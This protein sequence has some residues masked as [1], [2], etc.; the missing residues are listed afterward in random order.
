MSSRLQDLFLPIRTQFAA[1]YFMI[2]QRG[3]TSADAGMLRQELMEEMLG[4]PYVSSVMFGDEAGRQYLVMRYGERVRTSPLLGDV[5]PERVPDPAMGPMIFTREVRPVAWGDRSEWTFWKLEGEARLVESWSKPLPGYDPRERPWHQLAMQRLRAREGAGVRSLADP[6]PGPDWTEVYTFFTTKTPGISATLAARTP[7]G[8]VQIIAYDL[9][10]D[11]IARFTREAVVSRHGIVCVLTDDDRILGQSGKA[12][13]TILPSVEEGGPPSLQ[14]AVAR[15]RSRG[16]GAT[17]SFEFEVEGRSWWAGFAPYEIQAGRT[18]WIGVLAP[19]SDLLPEVLSFRVTLLV[20]GGSVLVLAL[21]LAFWLARRFAEPLEALAQQSEAT[22]RLDWEGLAPVTGPVAEIDTLARA[23]AQMRHALREHVD[24]RAEAEDALAR[25]EVRY[26]TLIDSAV[27]GVLVVKDQRVVFANAAA[28]AILNPKTAT[29]TPSTGDRTALLD[30]KARASV[31]QALA[32]AS[33]PASTGLV[34]SMQK[35]DGTETWVEA[36]LG[37]VEWEGRAA[38][39]LILRDLTELRVAQHRESELEEQ[40]RQSQKLEAVGQLAAGVAHDFNNLLQVISGQAALAASGGLSAEQLAEAHATIDRTVNS[41]SGLTRK[42]LTF[43][44]NQP[45]N[46]QVIELGELVANHIALVGRTIPENIRVHLDAAEEPLWVRG[47]R[48]LL[49]QVLLNVLINARDAMPS[50]GT[51]HCRLSAQ[52]ATPVDGAGMVELEVIDT[53]LGMDEVTRQ[54]AFEPFF[55]TKSLDRGNGL[56]LSV[57]Y[58]IVYQHGGA[59]DLASAVG[60]GTTVTITLPRVSPAITPR[61]AEA[62]RRADA[63]GAQSLTV[64]LAEDNDAVRE[65][66]VLALGSAGHTVVAARDGSEGWTIFQENP[67]R[68]DLLFFDVM[69]PGLNG[70][71]LA[72]R[73]RSMR[74]ELP[75]LFASGYAG[76]TREQADPDLAEAEILPKPY[77]LG[78]LRDAIARALE[79]GGRAT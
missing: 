41:A 72:Q 10:L 30:T 70:F 7:S 75:L 45:F 63:A 56:G 79:R 34:W 71:E 60:L 37:P 74:P 68:F 50:G 40:L 25:S 13:S 55:T 12:L 17:G 3:F 47:D 59:I 29:M 44:R 65:V 2:T 53:G 11:D 8:E 33:L 18:L 62:P 78:E 23:H 31:V 38:T 9:L 19:S 42:L 57:V 39:I 24:R 4:Q 22:M 48:V 77:L 58:G 20:V 67:R 14:A 49:E 76:A 15:R 5:A 28:V 66:A 6:A 43:S 27:L 64:L 52:T 26:R 73:C 61:L 46:P 32:A 1:D 21:W 16:P 51:L 36:S 35:T 69:M 54:R